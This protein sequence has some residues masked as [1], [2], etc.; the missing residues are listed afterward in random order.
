MEQQP[1]TSSPSNN[2][3]NYKGILL[4]NRP[5]QSIQKSTGSPGK[6]GDSG[7]MP[8]MPGGKVKDSYV[9]LP[10][11]QERNNANAA[12][13]FQLHQKQKYAPQASVTY[14]HKQYIRE[15][16]AQKQQEK[17]DK[18][19]QEMQNNDKKKKF[20]DSQQKLRQMMRDANY[21]DKEIKSFLRSGNAASK[22]TAESLKDALK[23]NKSS[24]SEKSPKKPKPAWLT[25]HKKHKEQVIPSE[26]DEEVDDLLDFANGLDFDEFIDDFEVR[27]ALAVI[28]SR[29]KEMEDEL[30]EEE[31]EER[32]RQRK[33]RI[34]EARERGST[35]REQL[36][37]YK[38]SQ[39]PTQVARHDKDWDPST[40]V[41]DNQSM[42]SDTS[43]I[44][45]NPVKN[46]HSK[47]SFSN[48]TKHANKR[49]STSNSAQPK[50]E[51]LT[52]EET[53][54]QIERLM[55]NVHK[56]QAQRSVIVTHSPRRNAKGAEPVK[57]EETAPN[58]NPAESHSQNR[59]KSDY[60]QSLP[61]MYRCPSI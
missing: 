15:L 34:E 60:I 42:H 19:E 26:D 23:K 41:D 52:L 9:G 49:P 45:H 40:R 61:Y 35:L 56:Q 55:E 8:F 57:V 50:P 30:T 29:V 44:M 59:K 14:Q 33:Q 18:L 10:P 43:S 53:Q 21:S 17:L 36:A 51:E 39:G 58:T 13:K 47:T 27:E 1:A 37:A 38:S 32:D 22:V 11:D 25:E 48:A 12:A 31:K 7:P 3:A 16:Q 46:V 54:Q 28:H 6:R 4:S 5:P 20:Q 2:T 24:K